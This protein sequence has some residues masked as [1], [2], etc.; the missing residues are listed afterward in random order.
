[1]SEAH[2]LEEEVLTKICPGAD[3][4]AYVCSLPMSQKQ[5]LPYKQPQT[6]QP[7][8]VPRI[9]QASHRGLPDYPSMLP[10]TPKSHPY[11]GSPRGGSIEGVVGEPMISGL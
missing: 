9:S 7:N 8:Q 5:H 2:T 4:R 1:M 11:L 6:Q 10:S 3:L